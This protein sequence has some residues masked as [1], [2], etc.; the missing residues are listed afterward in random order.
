MTALE[1][2]QSVPDWIIVAAAVV[3][4][5]AVIWSKV[6]QPTIRAG[7]D[8]HEGVVFVQ[9]MMRP[10]GGS[11]VIDRLDRLERRVAELAQTNA[12]EDRY[13]KRYGPD[14]TEIAEAINDEETP[15]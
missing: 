12:E 8:V 15:E 4:G 1:R 6:I 11:S 13:G 10:N 3:L 14:A 7:K 9:M 2:I 5:V